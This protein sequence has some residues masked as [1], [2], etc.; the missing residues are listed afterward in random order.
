MKDSDALKVLLDYRLEQAE[1]A[2]S[3]GDLLKQAGHR[4]G[5]LNRY[6]YAMFYDIQA[7]VT[8]KRAKISKH[9]GA[10]SFFDRE[11]IKSGIFD[12]KFSK[13]LHRLFDFRQDADIWRYV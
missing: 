9:S 4:R 1:E 3:A 5:A 7:L 10:L 2:L 6:Y 8:M 12:K 13:W 11:F